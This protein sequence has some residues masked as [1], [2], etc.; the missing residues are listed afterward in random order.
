MDCSLPGSSS[1]GIFQAR[2]LECCHFLLQ[3]GSIVKAAFACCCCPSVPSGRVCT[4]GLL[5]WGEWSTAQ[6]LYCSSRWPGWGWRMFQVLRQ[7]D[8]K[9][10]N[11]GQ[12]ESHL[13]TNPQVQYGST[14]DFFFP[15]SLIRKT[16]L[17]GETGSSAWKRDVLGIRFCVHLPLP[18]WI[19]SFLVPHTSHTMLV[20]SQVC[21]AGLMRKMNKSKWRRFRSVSLWCW[22][23][24]TETK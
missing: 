11:G 4:S 14:L 18:H 2:I 16:I 20:C 8:H 23:W 24:E 1:H 22:E 6:L 5:C 7:G 10:Q 17:G 3:G 13:T 9:R 12:M 15:D 19:W 21:C